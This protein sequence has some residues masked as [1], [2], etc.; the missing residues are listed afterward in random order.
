MRAIFVHDNF[1]FQEFGTENYY[2]SNG[3]FPPYVWDRYLN[4]FNEVHVISRG[5]IIDHISEGLLLTSKP[6]VHF[7][8]IYN[9]KSSLDY[10]FKARHILKE[11]KMTYQSGDVV[12]IRLP[13]FLG[14]ICASHLQKN[15]IRYYTEVVG[16]V[17]DALWNY[18]SIISKM[19]TPYYYHRMKRNVRESSAS[20]YVTKH[21]LQYRY[22]NN[23][24][25]NHHA[26]NVE[27]PYFEGDLFEKRNYSLSRSFKVGLIANLDVK[28]KGFDVLFKAVAELPLEIDTQIYLVGG[29]GTDYVRRLAKRFEVSDRLNIIG[30]LSSGEKIFSFLDYLDIYVHPSKQ[31]GLPRAVIEAMHRACPVLASSVGGT[32]ELLSEEFLHRPGDYKMLKSQILRVYESENLRKLMGRRNYEMAQD[33]LNLRLEDQRSIFWTKVKEIHLEYN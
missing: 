6:G 13:S 16:C 25:I 14:G 20:I 11:F 9:L 7:H 30:V 12:I 32:P 5:K 2:D 24:I 33:Y 28:Y 3:G 8:L 18:G 17:S 4:H 15:K 1:F 22:P 21:F 31:E 26:S 29:G 23:S 27:I 10:I 19:I